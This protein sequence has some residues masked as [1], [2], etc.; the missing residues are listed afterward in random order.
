MVETCNVHLVITQQ[1]V[2]VNSYGDFEKN[3]MI[4]TGKIYQVL[5]YYVHEN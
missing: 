1:W 5:L 4:E 3:V 2:I